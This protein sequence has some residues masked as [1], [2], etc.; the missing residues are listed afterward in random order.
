MKTVQM[1]NFLEK[2]FGISRHLSHTHRPPK[3]P[4]LRKNL[5]IDLKTRGFSSDIDLISSKQIIKFEIST[6]PHG[7]WEYLGFPQNHP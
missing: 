5:Y 7:F 3:I 1:K 4:K 6:S 2:K